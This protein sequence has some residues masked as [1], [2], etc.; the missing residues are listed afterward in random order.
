[1]LREYEFTVI[2]KGDMPEADHA[3]IMEEYEKY[4]VADGGQILKRDEWGTKRL[5]FPIKKSYRGRYT[6][7]DFVGNPKNLAEVE[8]RM[9]I[10]DNILRFLSVRIGEDVDVERRKVELA[11]AEIEEEKRA[12]ANQI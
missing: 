3:K 9:R 11:K 8:R 7:Y 6:I 4:L 10:D 1:V 5:A 12:K 2:A